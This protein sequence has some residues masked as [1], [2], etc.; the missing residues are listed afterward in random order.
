[1]TADPGPAGA[2]PPGASTAGPSSFAPVPMPQRRTITCP[3]TRVT[4]PACDRPIPMLDVRDGHGF[5]RCTHRVG[6]FETRRACGQHIYWS[7]SSRLCTVIALTP[8]E[9]HTFDDGH[10]T[11]AEIAAA[12]GIAARGEAA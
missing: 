2:R 8:E 11:H 3:G 10:H 12:L 1:M 5:A 6:R 9:R 4:C 7:C